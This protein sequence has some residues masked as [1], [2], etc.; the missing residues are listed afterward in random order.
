MSRQ[1]YVFVGGLHRSGTSLLAQLL[2]AHPDVASVEGAPVPENEGVYLQGAIPHT[3]LSGLPGRFGFDDAQHLTEAS[4]FNTLAVRDYLSAQWDEW[5]EEKP[6]WRLEK[7]PV[8]LLRARLYQ[9]LFPTAQ[10]V[11]VTRHPVAVGLATAKWTPQAQADLLRHW[12]RAH[13]RLRADLAYLHCWQIVRYEDLTRDPRATLAR[14]CG[15]LGIAAIA[16][17][18]A[19]D[20]D[21]NDAYFDEWTTPPDAPTLTQAAA[22]GYAMDGDGRPRVDEMPGPRGRHY[23]NARTREIA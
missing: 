16:P 12:E 2:G 17:S 20:P 13:E 22:F 10:F 15:F 11:F 3:A 14:V 5:Y 7:S 8:N 19:I 1:R 4:D 23:F 18:Q 6:A 9:Q 21:V